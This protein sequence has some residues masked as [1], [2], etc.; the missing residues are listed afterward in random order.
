MQDQL[1]SIPLIIDRCVLLL[2]NH[3]SEENQMNL[4]LLISK[5]VL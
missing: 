5:I 3:A 4:T 2:S 1:N